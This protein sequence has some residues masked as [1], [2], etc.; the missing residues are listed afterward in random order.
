MSR[1][2]EEPIYAFI[3]S[4]NALYPEMD[5][6]VRA[7]DGIANGQRVRV[8][9][10]EFRNAARLRLYWT[11][12]HRVV[13]ATECAP[14]AEHLHQAIKLELGFAT[15]V[16]LSNNMKVLVPDSISFDA[17]DEATFMAFFD[18]ATQFL[19]STYGID[20]LEFYDGKAA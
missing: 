19:S 9:V 6:D 11:V 3:R 18:R 7:L 12:L 4:G 10:K 16:L 13:E 15:P 5:M 1:K 20:P 14:T 2:K 17:M 8:V